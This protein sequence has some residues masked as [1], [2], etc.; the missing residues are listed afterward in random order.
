MSMETSGSLYFPFIW[1]QI[2]LYKNTCLIRLKAWSA[3]VFC[4]W[5]INMGAMVK[6]NAQEI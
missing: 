4:V 6:I 5:K 1:E 3:S 2:N